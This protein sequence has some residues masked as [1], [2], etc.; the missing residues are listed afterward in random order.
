[1]PSVI[2][3]TL[4]HELLLRTDSPEV[5]AKLMFMNTEPRIPDRRLK[6]VNLEIEPVGAFFR[7]CPPGLPAAEGSLETVAQAAYRLIAAWWST[8]INSAPVMHAAMA[9]IDGCRVVFVGDK[10]AG[11]T[12]LMLKLIQE[13]CAVQGDENL[14]VTGGGAIA[15]PRC[16]HVKESSL[17][18]LPALSEQ[19]RPL[20]FVTDWIGNVVYSCPPN[21]TGA[22]WTIVEGPVDALVFLEPNFGGSSV[23]SP[24]GQERAFEQV[25]ENAF[26]PTT[27]RARAVARLRTLALGCCCW[28][29]QTGNLDQAIE[30]LRRLASKGYGRTSA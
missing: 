9:V 8:E 17:D 11:K 15:T 1:L 21:F 27:G 7:I 22:E 10:H 23:L 20:P 30:R 19:I 28:R 25:L 26:L 13:G 2:V 24:L 16:L 12:T 5:R 14:I 6:T 18:V 4:S 29:L 3:R